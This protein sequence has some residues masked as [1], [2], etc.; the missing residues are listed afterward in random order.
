MKLELRAVRFKF[1]YK[2]STN[3][4]KITDLLQLLLNE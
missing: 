4:N 3:K 1:S 2:Y